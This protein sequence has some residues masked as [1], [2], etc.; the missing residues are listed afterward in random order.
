M[1]KPK[2]NRRRNWTFCVYPDSAP[3]DWKS[4][5]E[6][7]KVPCLISPLHDKDTWTEEDERK[8]PEHKAGTFKKPHWHVMLCYSGKKSFEQIMDI[9]TMCNGARCEPVES[10]AG[11]AA[12]LTHENNPEK[13]HYDKNEIEQFSGASYAAIMAEDKQFKDIIIGEMLDWCDEYSIYAYA[14]LLRYARHEKPDWFHVLN[15]TSTNQMVAFLKSKSWQ[16]KLTS[17]Q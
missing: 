12:Y 17:N 3:E 6:N 16:D 4:K 13:Y 15:H 1:S 7:L 14:D 8:N 2:D 5:I 10:K 9:V 11:M